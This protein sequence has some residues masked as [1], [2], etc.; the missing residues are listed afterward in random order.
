MR[1]TNVNTLSALLDRLITENI[2]K[3]FFEKEGSHDK[4]YHQSTVIRQL[5][6]EIADCF[7]ICFDERK[8]DYVGEKRTYKFG[9]VVETL[10]DLIHSDII[11]GEYDRANL[12]EAMTENASADAFKR[13][14]KIIRK[15]NETRANNKND[16]D[17]QFKDTVE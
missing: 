11:T 3:F 1:I 4:A 16:I 8:Y 6:I 14:H 10:E 15:A 17:S 9:D 2:K 5:R 12:Q 7:R 13:N